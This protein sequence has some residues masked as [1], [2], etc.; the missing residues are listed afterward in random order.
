[1]TQA[2]TPPKIPNAIKP[3]FT[4]TADNPETESSVIRTMLDKKGADDEAER[5]KAA[6]MV[7]I[8][9]DEQKNPAGNAG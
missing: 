3:T 8:R 4:V 2:P 7:N 1:M 6:G 5:L 9:I